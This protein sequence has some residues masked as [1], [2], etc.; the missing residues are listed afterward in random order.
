MSWEEHRKHPRFLTAVPVLIF[1]DLF[2]TKGHT[3]NLSRGGGVIAAAYAP[4][5]GQHL[6]LLLQVPTPGVAIKIPLVVVRWIAPGLF[7]VEFIRLSGPD[8][9]RL[10]HYLRVID[11]SPP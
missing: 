1:G 2:D 3:V 11:L 10:H 4:E 5:K 8:Q 6:Y 9:T 7:G